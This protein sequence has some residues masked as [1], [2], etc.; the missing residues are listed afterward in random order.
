MKTR[1]IVKF[2]KFVSNQDYKRIMNCLLTGWDEK[3]IIATSPD[4]EV[5]AIILEDEKGEI[6]V[7]DLA[8]GSVKNR[9]KTLEKIKKLFK[10]KN[11]A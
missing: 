1:M 10:K 2:N 3:G 4:V 11:K 7:I 8:N 9:E 6:K 5:Q